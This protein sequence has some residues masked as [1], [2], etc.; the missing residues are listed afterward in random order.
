MHRIDDFR[1]V[2]SQ[3]R[4]RTGFDLEDSPEVA[5]R[6]RFVGLVKNRTKTITAN[7]ELALAA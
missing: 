3:F 5:C 6:G 7:E 2:G 4:G 1:D